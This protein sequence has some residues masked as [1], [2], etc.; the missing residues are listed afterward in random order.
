M[1]NIFASG[2]ISSTGTINS[3]GPMSTGGTIQVN[4]SGSINVDGPV[5][6]G[7]GTINL[8]AGSGIT[9]S[10]AL[11]I[12]TSGTLVTARAG[13]G[14]IGSSATPLLVTAPTAS[15]TGDQ[16]AATSGAGHVFA[17]LTGTDNLTLVGDHGF[18]VSSDTAFS[19]LSVTTRGSG[20]GTPGSSTLN[21]T[22]PNQSYSF[23]RPGTDLFSTAITNTFQ[24]VS[25]GGTTPPTN[26]TFNASDGDLLVG[27]PGT[28]AATNL[29]LNAQSS[30]GDLKLQ[31][32]T[33]SPLNLSHTTQNFGAGRDLL[34]RGNVAL[35]AGTTQSLF[36][37]R[38]LTAQAEGGTIAFSAAN[39]NIQSFSSG[40]I[41]FLGGTLANET[42]TVSVTGSQTISTN[43]FG[44]GGVLL[45]GGTGAGSSVT[46]SHTGSGSQSITAGG[47]ITVQGGAD[48][49]VAGIINAAGSQYVASNT[50]VNVRGGPGTDA[51]ARIVNTSTADQ[52][53]GESRSF[54]SF[55][56]NNL[57]VKG[58]AGAGAFAEIV[59]AGPQQIYSQ[60]GT[61]N[62]EGGAGTNATAKIE[63]TSTNEQQIGFPDYLF[64]CGSRIGSVIIKGGTGTGSFA[65]IDANGLQ[66]VT[67]NSSIALTGT[68]TDAGAV[69]S[70]ASQ[71]IRNPSITLVAGAG[72][73]ANALI[74]SD[75]SQFI[76]PGN[77]TLTGGGG[78][79]ATATAKITAAGL[80]QIFASAMSLTSGPG[81][82]SVAQI[83]TT[84][85]QTIN[86]SSLAL[87]ALNGGN[88]SF[89]KIDAVTAGTTQ[90]L[91]G[92]NVT[93]T[94]GG[95]GQSVE[96]F[97]AVPNASA[98]IE[99]HSQQIFSGAMTL[100]GGAGASGSTSDAII[101][102]LSGS[103]NVFTSSITL[104]GG[105]TQST[106]GILNLGTGTQTV[107]GSNGITLRSDPNLPPAH[108]DSFVLIQNPAATLQTITANFGGLTLTNSGAGTVEVTSAGTQA[109]TSHFVDVTTSAGGAGNATLSATGNQRIHTT[110]ETGPLFF[111]VRVAALGTGT[112]SV[113]SGASQL[114]EV[115][116][117]EVMQ[118]SGLTG[119]MV[120]GDVNVAGTSRIKAVDQT[121]VAGSI[122]V[123]SGAVGSISELK[124]SGTQTVS[125]LTG[126]ISVL[127][128][129]GDNS[130]A[131]I[132]PTT[133]T[134]L[135]NGTLAVQGGSGVNAIAQIVSGSAQT[136]YTTNG[137]FTLSGGSASGAAAFITN[138]GPAS[139]LGTTG[140][141][142][143]TPGTAPGAD[144]LITV[145]PGGSGT[146]FLACGGSCILPAVGPSPTAGALASGGVVIGPALPT[147]LLPISTAT[148]TNA[149]LAAE[150]AN[151]S[152]QSLLALEEDQE[153]TRLE[154][155]PETADAE[156]TSQPGVPICT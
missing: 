7:P 23:A 30:T 15:L 71:D 93:L 63:S 84:G 135:S 132:D 123:Q 139:I 125:T 120:I 14:D 144:A 33:A 127:G 151:D 48:N 117:P 11:S 126:G 21:L 149:A 22:A 87:S 118:S 81:A 58:G 83:T 70:G 122:V 19:T 20:T 148:V 36:A 98:I 106:T 156:S 57:E 99:G 115:T 74:A 129:S 27:G 112:A 91:S 76:D 100:N 90:S 2:G 103:Q 128:G 46:V 138:G 35:S 85:N 43:I 5:S 67:A 44:A 37:S 26:A 121:V 17:T 150:A 49:S 25:V 62:V 130:L 114:L 24:V 137:D 102:N 96:P 101:R 40:S 111:G 143:L 61:L 72:N 59:A 10:G 104:N 38:N 53:I 31:G 47:N 34:V 113:E 92:G 140:D 9:R 68:T 107:S 110:N 55:Q 153:D 28:I 13:D 12:V 155:E 45:Q 109:V 1:V 94:A 52:T 42:V 50:D 66:R 154:A 152:T 6:S 69:L 65:H 51:V 145:G 88:G 119:A 80:Q 56:T 29:T 131:Q 116:Y 134:I 3:T 86:F 136:I 133:Q 124:A 16:F 75:T 18:N 95:S 108:A 77:V 54:T 4:V 32:T 147:G 142:I 73:N 64:C 89:A 97:V 79:G 60:F 8:Q 105:H 146:L 41:S 141:V 39:Q 78:A 82:N